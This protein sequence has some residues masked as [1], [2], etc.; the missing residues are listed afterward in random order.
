MKVKATIRKSSDKKEPPKRTPIVVS[1]PNDPRLRAYQDSLNLYNKN[2]AYL[3]AMSEDAYNTWKVRANNLAKNQDEYYNMIYPKSKNYLN[4]AD[5]F[6]GYKRISNVENVPNEKKTY[7]ALVGGFEK[8]D[9]LIKGTG[10]FEDANLYRKNTVGY[11]KPVQPVIFKAKEKEK[12]ERM[13]PT[14]KKIFEKEETPKIK[15]TPTAVK[16][17]ELIYRVEYFDPESG[18]KAAKFFP[19]EKQGSEFQKSLS[20]EQN[21]YGSRGMY[22]KN[23]NK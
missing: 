5:K 8:T 9:K 4:L 15:K 12:I 21:K 2:E 7:L 22:V 18:K 1:N 10:K 17:S 11:K 6:Y 14:A 23:E 13:E 20:S 16:P 3:K 19:N